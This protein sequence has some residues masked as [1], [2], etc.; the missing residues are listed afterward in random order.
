MVSN[1]ESESEVEEKQMHIW[2]FM[3]Q[4]DLRNSKFCY[5]LEWSTALAT[6]TAISSCSLQSVEPSIV[7]E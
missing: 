6:G 7:H 1:T 3:A 4:D 5:Y 2:V